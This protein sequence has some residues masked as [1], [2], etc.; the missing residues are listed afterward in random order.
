MDEVNICHVVAAQLPAQF[1]HHLSSLWG[2]FLLH[3]AALVKASNRRRVVWL[4]NP[5]TPLG[6]YFPKPSTPWYGLASTSGKVSESDTISQE[7]VYKAEPMHAPGR[8]QGRLMSATG[9]GVFVEGSCHL[10]TC[11]VL[12]FQAQ[13]C[14]LPPIPGASPTPDT[15]NKFRLCFWSQ[16][17][18]SLLATTMQV[19]SVWS[20]I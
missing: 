16:S 20:K 3:W 17:L 4:Q 13:L 19:I 12:L 14:S 15:S 2:N 6:A 18:F 11:R 5:K 9:P 10:W 8:C 1:Q 7:S